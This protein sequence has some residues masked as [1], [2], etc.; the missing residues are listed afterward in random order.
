MTNFYRALSSQTDLTSYNSGYAILTE[1]GETLE[2]ASRQ[3]EKQ[4]FQLQMYFHCAVTVLKKNPKQ[5]LRGKKVMD[6]GCG[7]GGGLA[8]LAKYLAPEEA[9]G[10]DL[11]NW[12]IQF[13]QHRHQELENIKFVEQDIRSI[14]SNSQL[15]NLDLCLAIESFGR[16][17]NKKEILA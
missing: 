4:K 11:S 12:Q 8:F 14:T 7:R 16:F 9:I 2:L 1:T 10:V 5:A 17:S 3:D 15:H 13:C 6:L